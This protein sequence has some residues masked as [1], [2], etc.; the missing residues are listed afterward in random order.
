MLKRISILAL[1]LFLSASGVLAQDN[2]SSQT[3]TQTRTLT[4]GQ[5]YKIQGV[6]VGRD[7]D[8]FVVRDTGGIDTKVILATN[9][10][11]KTKGGVFG[12]SKTV[13]LNSI[14]RG[15]NLEVEGR[16]DNSGV[17]AANKIRFT[18]NDLA[19]AQSIESRVAPAE[20]RLSQAEQNAQR[21]SGQIDELSAI[22]NA[23]RGGAKAAQDAADAAISGVNAT[24]QRISSVDDYVVQS[25]Q[26]VNFKVGSSVLMPEGKTSLDT[27]A[28]NALTI[29]GYLIEVTGFASAE[30]NAKKNKEL[31]RRRAQAVLDYLIETHNIPLRRIGVSY[32][33]GAAQPVADNS[34]A[35]GRAQNRRVEVKLTV[36]KGLNQTVE[37]KKDNSNQ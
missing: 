11:V 31:S 2:S 3:A 34:T 15:L 21:I 17:L 28:Q 1:A 19:T 32:G 16:G 22:S 18:K 12:G 14:V 29:K 20:E 5:K 35:E 30:G 10:S 4:S 25:T 37:V 36:S 7:N 9:S 33:F 8:S 24:N 23:A 6:V 26:T 13:P 27:I